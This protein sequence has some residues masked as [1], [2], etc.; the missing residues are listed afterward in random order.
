MFAALGDISHRNGKQSGDDEFR[1]SIPIFLLLLCKLVTRTRHASRAGPSFVQIVAHL[2]NVTHSSRS[3]RNQHLFLI[4]V[5]QRGA[6]LGDPFEVKGLRDRA[7]FGVI[8]LEHRLQE[9]DDF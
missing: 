6:R 1:F 9:R 7:S 5:F 3:P 4:G 2:T 8:S